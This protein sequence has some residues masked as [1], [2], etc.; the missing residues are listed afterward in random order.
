MANIQD[1]ARLAGVSTATVSRY[2]SGD[3]V[4]SADRVAAA[5]REL[6]F[7]PSLTA[8]GLRTRRHLAVGVVVPDIANPFFAGVTR[9]IENV[10]A[11]EGLQLAIANSGESVRR[12][13]ELVQDLQQRV[14]GI[15]L[16]PATET[17]AV[18]LR[19]AESGLPVVF[20]DRGVEER[21]EFDMVK[22]ANVSGA[23]Q[24]VEHLADL[25]HRAIGLVSG[26]LTS[27]P[28]RER[29]DG[30]LAALEKRGIGSLQEHIQFADF[31]ESGGYAA[32]RRVLELPEP[33]SA[34]FVANNLMSI[35]ALKAARD[36]GLG[37]P[38]D[39]SVVGFDDL[40]LGSLLDPPFTVIDRPSIAQGEEAARLM[41]E[42]L[43]DPGRPPRTVVMPVRLVVR[44][45]TAA[46]R[47]SDD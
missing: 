35:G 25:G 44:A 18:P 33:P 21:G 3:H 32:M 6:G 30:F 4:R 20:I 22:V 16:A 38:R 23:M 7:R 14:D 12:E 42:R 27:T 15:L 34:V 13:A 28:G 46:P 19:L 24:A 17:D 31:Q 1:V 37:V 10:L 43:R 45:S 8:R 39:V 11:P 2:L 36:L 29:H 26:P 40:D 5:V 41:V 47:R 9:G